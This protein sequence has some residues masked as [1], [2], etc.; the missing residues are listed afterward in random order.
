V[1]AEGPTKGPAPQA[2]PRCGAGVCDCADVS[3]MLLEVIGVGDQ[4]SLTLATA[5]HIHGD[6]RK[7]RLEVRYPAMFGPEA[8]VIA[9]S[10]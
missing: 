6:D 10:M 9:E 7:R 4:W 5:A 2:K 8:P 3:K 1:E